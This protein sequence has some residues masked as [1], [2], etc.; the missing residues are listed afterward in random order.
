[1]KKAACTLLFLL[2]TLSVRAALVDDFE[3]YTTGPISQ[4]TGGQWVPMFGNAGTDP[5]TDSEVRSI[6]VDPTDAMNKAIYIE[7]T[8]AGQ[9]SMYGV[10]PSECII[11]DGTTRT[12]FTRFYATGTGID[13]SLGLSSV[14]AP[15]TFNNFLVQVALVRG[16]V[17]VRNAGG[18]TTV[19]TFAGSTWYYLWIV[20]NNSTNTYSV[21]LKTTPS[22]ATTADRIAENFAF[23]SIG[24]TN[25]DGDLDRFLTVANYGSGN[26]AGTR[27][28][29]DDM[30]VTEGIDL[31]IPA[32]N[33]PYNAS[34]N[35]TPDTENDDIDVIL[36][37]NA[38]PDPAQVYAVNPD[39]VD[40]YVFMGSGSDPNLY[41]VGAT[42]IDPGV[43]DPASEYGPLNLVPG[44]T[45]RW[46]VVEALDGYQQSFTTSDELADVDPNNIIGP[47][48]TF[49]TVLLVPSFTGVPVDQWVFPGNPAEFSVTLLNA[50]GT[51][52]QW[53]KDSTAI[54]GA[55]SATLTIANAQLADEG[56]YFCRATNTAGS[57]DS[58]PAILRIKRIVSHYP[59]ETDLLDTV[60]GFDLTPM[61]EGTAGLPTL[62][63]ASVDASVG[64][65]SLDFNNG[66]HAADPNGQYAQIA[67][68]V[69]DYPDLSITGWV[70]WRGG[71]NWQRVFDFGVDTA[72]YMLLTPSNG[73]ECRFVLNN[74][75]G[76][77]IL[78]TSPLTSGEWVFVAATL[79]GNTGRFYLNGELKATNTSMTINP[80]DIAPTMNY[81][82]KSQY[83]VDPEFDGMIDDLK[84]YNYALEIQ[85]IA[86]EYYD[87]TGIDP[88]IDPQFA[89]SRFNLDNTGS[90]YCKV[91][92]ADFAVFAE[93]WLA[94]GLHGIQ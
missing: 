45:Y 88:C 65:Y 31:S 2:A 94:S 33:K 18:S 84:I 91:D 68:G 57:T 66:D 22:A 86:Q 46:A 72:H 8:N 67:S 5:G 16:S 17:L 42:G 40:E 59:L 77:Q 53:Y 9:Y 56:S 10:L 64:S 36:R 25:P 27:V 34:V 87:A 3:G 1:M 62:V 20:V 80:A 11:P 60:S 61:Q 50:N 63:A 7:T 4:V 81:L 74:G 24:T 37:W 28:Y 44:Q 21:Y 30:A 89:G 93:A 23:R 58:D 90:S 83:E 19:S 49:T 26:T 82:G 41:Y 38:A 51:S 79:E 76:E 48:W 29:F 39:I 35:Q 71:A 52:Y 32:N 13:Q 85:T 43:D 12:F 54:D 70:F 6:A 14:D 15:T 73:S 47:V 55:V 75:S 69:V 92:L 78:A